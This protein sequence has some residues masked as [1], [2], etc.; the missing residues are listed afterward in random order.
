[1]KKIHIIGGGTFSHVA[2][3]LA[4]AAPAF[5]TV[6]REITKEWD[7]QFAKEKGPVLHL[8]KMADYQSK[9]VTNEDVC[10]LVDELI[11]DQDT[12]VIFFSAAMC[13]F[14]GSMSANSPTNLKYQPRLKTEQ[15]RQILHLTPAEKII[16]KIRKDRKDI[17]LVGFKTTAGDI[18]N[19][20]YLQGLKLLKS[21]SC[22]L[23]LAN[24]IRTRLNMI[25][26][27]E[28]ARYHETTDRAEIIKNLVEMTKLRSELHFTRSTIVPGNSIDWNSELVP[29][30]LRQVV[31]HCIF[32]GA[33][34]PFLGS[35]VGHFAIKIGDNKFLTS[36]RKTNFNKISDSAASEWEAHKHGGLVCVETKDDDQVIA[37]GSRPSVGGQSQRIVFAEHPD[38]DCIV[39]AH[40]PKKASSNVPVRSQREFECGSHECGRNTSSGLAKFD[41]PNGQ[42]LYA[43]ML[44]KHG[45]NIIF[46]KNTNPAA[47]IKFIDDN[48]Y[49]HLRTDDVDP[50][51]AQKFSYVQA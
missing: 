38:V 45:P 31:N 35:T 39:H 50:V 28:Q 2:P 21:A 17:F 26:T 27:P 29:D 3:H 19:E 13:D 1:M 42:Y 36:R 47:V 33:Y 51:Y 5:G 10:K 24:D 15:G 12:S 46:N 4:L 43:V 44:D 11:A 34:K 48:F 37:H 20:Q 49:L 16:K 25:I 41:L 14:N 8:T 9:L 32:H 40:V 7:F 6:A 23:V 18:P 22:N 30:S